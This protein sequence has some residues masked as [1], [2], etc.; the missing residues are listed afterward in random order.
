MQQYLDLGF[1]KPLLRRTKGVHIVFPREKLPLRRA[2]TLI[3][4]DGRVM[5]AIPWKDRTIIGTTDTDF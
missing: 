3:G 5:F 2:I 4:K 1:S